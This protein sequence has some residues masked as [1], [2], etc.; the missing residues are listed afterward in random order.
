MWCPRVLLGFIV[1]FLPQISSALYRADCRHRMGISLAVS[2]SAP[3]TFS[4]NSCLASAP[5]SRPHTTGTMR[6]PSRKTCARTISRQSHPTTCKHLKKKWVA[7][8]VL[9]AILMQAQ[10][11]KNHSMVCHHRP[12]HL[13]HQ[14][15]LELLLGLG[16]DHLP[17]ARVHGG[18]CLGRCTG[19]S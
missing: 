9:Y 2:Q 17:D 7:N 1:D 12:P 15:L 11:C 18:P 14:Y 5:Y 3:H 8:L 16:L 13:I 6:C 19:A 10:V 4:A